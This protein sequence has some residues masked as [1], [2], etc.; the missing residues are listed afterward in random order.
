MQDKKIII[1]DVAITYEDLTFA[2]KEDLTLMIKLKSSD[3]IN[4]ICYESEE[5]L[6]KDFDK[7]YKLFPPRGPAIMDIIKKR[8]NNKTEREELN[9]IDMDNPDKIKD[10]TG[11]DKKDY[12]YDEGLK[13]KDKKEKF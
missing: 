12:D 13:Q 10:K 6:D 9:E 3:N 8:D 1:K 4:Y 11:K 2:K 7:L 5:E